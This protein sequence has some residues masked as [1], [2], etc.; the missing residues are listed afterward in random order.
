[1]NAEEDQE[2]PTYVQLPPEDPDHGQLVA[3]L[4]R[5]MYGTRAAADGWQ[6]ECSTMLVQ[7][8]TFVQGTSCANVFRHDEKGI[9]ISVHGDDFQCLGSKRALDWLETEIKK[10]YECTVQPRL[11]PGPSDAKTGLV[12]NRVIHWNESSLSYEA[13]PRQL[14]RLVTECGLDGAKSVSTPGAK[15]SAA[16]LEQEL[17]FR[18]ELKTT[19]RVAADR[20]DAQFA[21]KEVCRWMS[22][23][24]T[25]SW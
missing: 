14:E 18:E 5:C 20:P 15:P 11:G 19:Y 13:D 3:K 10:R 21:C 24:S 6:T 12:L 7:E 25:A 8:L 23:P 16:E 22:S 17:P 9:K 4:L 2:N 1:M